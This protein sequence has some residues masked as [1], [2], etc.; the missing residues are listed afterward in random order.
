VILF[1]NRISSIQIADIKS[2]CRV[3]DVSPS[4]LKKEFLISEHGKFTGLFCRTQ[5]GF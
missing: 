3:M 1:M 2:F 5:E 4:Q